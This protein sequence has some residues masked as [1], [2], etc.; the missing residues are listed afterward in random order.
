MYTEKELSD[1]LDKLAKANMEAAEAIHVI[2]KLLTEE[3][4]NKEALEAM[5]GE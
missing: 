1:A 5:D 4:I 3:E 2:S